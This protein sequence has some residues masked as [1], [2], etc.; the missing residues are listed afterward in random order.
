MKRRLK[1]LTKQGDLMPDLDPDNYGDENLGEWIDS[2]IPP[3]PLGTTCE[4]D[5]CSGEARTYLW[6]V[7]G[8]HV[9][10]T[11]VCYDC[12]DVAEMYDPMSPEDYP[13]TEAGYAIAPTHCN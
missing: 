4:K 12:G 2:R 11:Y 5:G 13:T 6:T 1:I 8:D 7:E 3:I 9:C 10:F